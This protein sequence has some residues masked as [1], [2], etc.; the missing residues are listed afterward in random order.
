MRQ[1]DRRR[2]DVEFI[3]DQ[4]RFVDLVW[5]DSEKNQQVAIVQLLDT[6]MLD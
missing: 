1:Q 4:N 3:E 5:R 2:K 6:T